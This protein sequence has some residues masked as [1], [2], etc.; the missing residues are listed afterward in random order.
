MNLVSVTLE[1]IVE[2]TRRWPIEKVTELVDRLTEEFHLSP[3][4]VETAWKEETRRR[5]SEIE[6]GTAQLVDGDAVSARVRRIVGR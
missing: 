1:Q 3:S 4:E 6:G 2:E 5:L